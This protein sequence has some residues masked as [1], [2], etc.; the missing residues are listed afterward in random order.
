MKAL[1]T[2][3][4]YDSF[5]VGQKEIIESVL[6]G[7]D[8]LAML[9]TG[10][11]KSLCYLL[12]GY[13]LDGTVLIVTP[14]LSLMQDQV[15]QLKAQGE[16]RVIAINSF[17]SYQEKIRTIKNLH[18]YKFV[19]I[20]PEMLQNEWVL[21]HIKKLKLSLFVVDEA[22]CI[23]QWGYDFRPDYSQ[24]GN[25]R[26]FLNEPVTL[27]LTATAT[28]E[29]REDIKTTLSLENV[30]ELIF[31]VNRPNIAIQVFSEISS[32]EKKELT[33]Q[34]V[35]ELKKPGIIYFS[36]KKAADEWATKLQSVDG[37]KV[38]SYHAG[39]SQEKRILIQQQFLYNELDIICATSAFGMG[40]NKENVRFIIHYHPPLQMESYLQEIG[41]AGR[42]GLASV[43]IL[44]NGDGDE[45]LQFQLIEQELPTS[46]HIETFAE[47]MKK[48]VQSFTNIE[49]I[50]LLGFTEIQWRL[51]ERLWNQY[52]DQ[53][54]FTK[55]AEHYMNQRMETKIKKLYEFRLWIKNNTCRREQLLSFFD[56]K[57]EERPKNC[58]DVCGID[59]KLY[60]IHEE[61]VNHRPKI[62]WRMYLKELL[63]VK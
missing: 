4:S 62:E 61:R 41:R 29:V 18:N 58:C 40:I 26:K 1:R 5:R 42:D 43:A 9:P 28:K 53:R 20:S 55:M 57:L 48:Q 38:A 15:E 59:W 30:K 31:S 3:F 54:S 36:S 11:G 52:S 22:H 45:R 39:L 51:L 27:A 46:V 10:S 13:M 37:I 32:F 21:D 47:L 25:V 34:F 2:Y 56:E 24:L 33:I 60:N 63:N 12:P 19:Y 14:L 6:S 35:K 17:L 23:S 50:K 7:Y 16:K 49:Q 8:T 44:F